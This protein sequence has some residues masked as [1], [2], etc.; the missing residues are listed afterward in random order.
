MTR[1]W[2]LAIDATEPALALDVPDHVQPQTMHALGASLAAS[3]SIE[4][5]LLRIARYS[6]LVTDAAD[7]VLELEPDRVNVIYRAPTRDL[8]LANA[9]FEAFMATGVQMAR[10]LGGGNGGLL[11]C[12]FRH[13]A[14]SAGT[15][16]YRRYFGCPVRFAARDNRLVFD[17]LRVQ[18]PLPGAD[19]R[20]AR[21]HDAAAAGYLARFDAQPVSQKLREQLIRHLPS[22]EP[23]RAR[24]AAALHLTPRTLLRRL[25]AENTNWKTLLNDVR[26]ELALSYLRQNRS[27]AEITYLL[28][29]ADP[30]NFTRA[31]RRWT[32][33]VPTRWKSQAPRG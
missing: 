7:I 27:A 16:A 10:Q 28:G 2:Q 22:G 15:A 26:R 12:E 19:E 32:G 11:A 17:R 29:F 21:L 8:P 4:E 30:A 20:A 3:R 23:T 1:F 25:A 14:P 5:A 6:R 31:F 13:A 18:A 33:T 24:L 9:A